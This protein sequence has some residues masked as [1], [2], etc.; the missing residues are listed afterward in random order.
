VLHQ[1]GEVGDDNV[2]AV[3]FQ[4]LCLPDAAASGG[5]SS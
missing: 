5:S 3:L 1:L 2:R 4:R